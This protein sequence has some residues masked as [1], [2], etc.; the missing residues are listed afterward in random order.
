MK[1]EFKAKLLQHLLRDKQEGF[2]LIELLVVVI[3]IG[4][5]AAVALPNL[6][7]QVGKARESEAK[8]AVG[9]VNRAQQAYQFEH[10]S[11]ATGSGSAAVEGLLGVSLASQY[12]KYTFAGT[13]DSYANIVAV[14]PNNATNNTRPYSGT[15]NFS[16]GNYSQVLCQGQF[17]STT[18][19]A[20]TD[21]TCPANYT[22]IQ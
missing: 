12:Y 21:A 17:A 9:T 5:L 2:T 13:G 6:L 7:A 4:V 3:I 22:L 10:L 15:I 16:S 19:T 8:D 18:G 14:D 20:N 11:F 1:T